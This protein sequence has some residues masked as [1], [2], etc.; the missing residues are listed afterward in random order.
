MAGPGD[1]EQSEL[2]KTPLPVEPDATAAA[3]DRVAIDDL[4]AAPPPLAGI[5]PGLPLMPPD[6]G[7]KSSIEPFATLPAKARKPGSEVDKL[8]ALA[9]A[10]LAAQDY[11]AAVDA[12]RRVLNLNP[13]SPAAHGNLA[14]ALWRDK[15]EPQAEI[16]CRRAIAL[17]A[18]YI[19]AFRMLAELLRR[20]NA[21]E[22]FACYSRL[23]AL[24]PDNFM[25]HN[26]VGLLLGKLGR[27][28]EA[29]A[30]FARAL[31]LKPGNPEIRFNQIMTRQNDVELGEAVTCCRRSLENR[32]DD[33][34]VLTNLA[35]V[36]HFSGRHEDA[37][38]T[39]ERAI[40][41]DG[42]HLG[43]HFN[44]SLLLLLGDYARGFHE[45]EQRW[46]MLEVK[47]PSFAQ[48]EWAGE[49]IEGKTILLHSEQGFGD[50]IQCLRYVRMVTARGARVALRLER[51][52]VRLAASLPG[53]IVI[54]PTNARLPAFDVWC[55]L[56]SLLRILGTRADAIPAS[57]PYLGVRNVIAERWQRRLAGLPGLKIG[58][59][60]GGSPQHVND[61]RRSVGLDR[62]KPLLEMPGAS[63]VSLLV[64]PRAADLAALPPN[65]VTDLSHELTDFA[66]TAGAIMNL[67]IVIAV[68]T[69]VAHL[70][71]ALNRPAWI[72]LPFSPDW[73]WMLNRNDSPWYPSLRLYRQPAPGDWDSVIVRVAAD[74]AALAANH[75]AAAPAIGG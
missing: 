31:E 14:L 59:A 61:A 58:L 66:E 18:R 2:L 17:N 40:A 29:D 41:A 33:P 16:H 55:P 30:A 49:E 34:D 44:L 62:L 48:P 56:L 23:L 54:T 64:G 75:A 50:S 37:H 70:A 32:P 4:E 22:A 57:V 3:D 51:P 45:Y 53:N 39:Y 35:V 47:K 11:P 24:D 63:F 69:A 65:T 13:D 42:N 72:M 15:C 9:G 43:A 12:L 46:R 36:L 71:G 21:P 1:P 27:R 68:D 7:G 26:N 5:A 73:R 74:L 8:N 38:A 67:D 19:P 28:S 25:A 60:W 6:D 52:L 10:K 20:R